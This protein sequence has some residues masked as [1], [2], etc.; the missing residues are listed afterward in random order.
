MLESCAFK[1]LTRKHENFQITVQYLDVSI[2]MTKQETK[3]NIYNVCF[4]F[5]EGQLSQAIN[6]SL[7]LIIVYYCLVR[8]GS[9][10]RHFN[11]KYLVQHSERKHGP[12]C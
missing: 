8:S 7:Q 3:D 9:F 12:C 11:Y 2:E 5:Y 4:A 10:Y 6:V 1:Q